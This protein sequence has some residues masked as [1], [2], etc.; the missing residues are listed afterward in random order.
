MG[1]IHVLGR[2]AGEEMMPRF[3]FLLLPRPIA[4]HL[5]QR[6]NIPL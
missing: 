6:L 1:A 3:A 5:P 4:A 2:R